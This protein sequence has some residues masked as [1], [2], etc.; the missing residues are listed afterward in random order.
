MDRVMTLSPQELRSPVCYAKQGITLGPEILK[1][2]FNGN[3]NDIGN[4][5]IEMDWRC[6]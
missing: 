1:Q 5:V 2:P 6:W 4:I 3:T